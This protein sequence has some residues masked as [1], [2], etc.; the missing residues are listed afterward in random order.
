M[1]AGARVYRA[2]M[3]KQAEH[4]IRGAASVATGAGPLPA[5]LLMN[6]PA[7]GVAAVVGWIAMNTDE[8]AAS[9]IAWLFFAMAAFWAAL[10]T[11]ESWRVLRRFAQRAAHEALSRE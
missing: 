7:W 9:A 8:P 1:E 6:L 5:A 4:R 11:S 10:V 2:R 3:R